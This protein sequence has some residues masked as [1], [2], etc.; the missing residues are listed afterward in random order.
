[1][2]RYTQNI[3]KWAEHVDNY[4]E[5]YKKTWVTWEGVVKPFMDDEMFKDYGLFKGV[6]YEDLT[7]VTEQARKQLEAMK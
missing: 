1:M 6:K 2:N 3:A 5:Y 7:S 4:W